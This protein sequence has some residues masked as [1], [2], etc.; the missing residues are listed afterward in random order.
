MQE[1]INA[2]AIIDTFTESGTTALGLASKC[3]NVKCVNVLIKAGIDVDL[4]WAAPVM[5]PRQ[6]ER[7]LTR[8]AASL[9]DIEGSTPLYEAC[10]Y[11]STDCVRSLLQAGASL[12][13]GANVARFFFP[14]QYFLYDQNMHYTC[15]PL[16]A[17]AG[18]RNMDSF[19]MR[20]ENL[21]S[22]CRDVIRNHLLD[23]DPHTNLFFNRTSCLGLPPQMVSYLMFGTSLKFENE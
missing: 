8:G 9:R 6:Y 7:A 5:G 12:N 14:G 1:L 11:G 19:L 16:L 4:R 18:D 22:Y 10:A 21:A 17:A 2:G 13:V 23:I 20:D 3:A 15:A